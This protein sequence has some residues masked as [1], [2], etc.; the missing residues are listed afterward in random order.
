MLS[1][2]GVTDGEIKYPVMHLA[3][4]DLALSNPLEFI[5]GEQKSTE[6]SL[7]GGKTIEIEAMGLNSL[8]VNKKL[9]ISICGKSCLDLKK[10]SSFQK[11]ECTIP[12]IDTLF[13]NYFE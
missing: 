11:V 1:F 6:V 4:G 3:V 12:S 5:Y 10:G 8:L 13:S 9:D 2:E 7:R